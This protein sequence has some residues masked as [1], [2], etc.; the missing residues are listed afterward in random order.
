VCASPG[1]RDERLVGRGRRRDQPASVSTT[2]PAR[3]PSAA[4]A[5]RRVYQLGLGA[6]PTPGAV[7]IQRD[8]ARSLADDLCA[9]GEQSPDVLQAGPLVRPAD[10]CAAVA[11]ARTGVLVIA[12]VEARDGAAALATMLRAAEDPGSAAEVCLGALAVRAVRLLC[13]A[14]RAKDA[15]GSS[16]SGCATCSGT[17]RAAGSVRIAELLDAANLFGAGLDRGA[18]AHAIRAAVRELGRGGLD[19]RARELIER[20][21]A[22]THDVDRAGSV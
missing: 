22:S 3:T 19:D 12:R 18:N 5:G 1:T 15:E 9:V 21:L 6:P 20:G 17:G 16:A 4:A 8:S 10:W 13:P 14:C 2:S 7:A 11:V